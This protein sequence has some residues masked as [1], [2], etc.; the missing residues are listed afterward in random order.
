MKLRYIPGDYPT[1]ML[2][3]NYEPNEAA[4]NAFLQEE[5]FLFKSADLFSKKDKH[6]YNMNAYIIYDDKDYHIKS[7]RI[8]SFPYLVYIFRSMGKPFEFE[9]TT[10]EF[11]I[12]KE[13]FEFFE[14]E[15]EIVDNLL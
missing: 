8:N 15:F 10:S 13:D 4:Y 7:L 1:P 5:D 11:A 9:L 6:A 2:M 12:I 3:I 14:H